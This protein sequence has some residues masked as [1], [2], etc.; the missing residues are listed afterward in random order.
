MDNSWAE[1][2]SIRSGPTPYNMCFYAVILVIRAS[3]KT[4]LVRAFWILMLYSRT[5]AYANDLQALNEQLKQAQRQQA[6]DSD[7]P[8]YTPATCRACHA[9]SVL[10]SD[11]NQ[12]S[13]LDA[14]LSVRSTE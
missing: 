3:E 11:L 13:K 8:R 4:S 12:A 1:R 7:A 6:A 2:R 9:W 14:T 5:Q 10:S